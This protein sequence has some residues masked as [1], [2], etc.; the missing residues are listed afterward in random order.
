MHIEPGVVEGAKNYLSYATAAGAL[1]YTVKLSL[2]IIKHDGVAALLLRSAIATAL[3]FCF[4]EVLPH[5]PVGVSEVHLVLGTTLLLIFGVAPAA[6]GLSIGLLIQGL[7][8]E[9]QDIP[10]YGMNVTT[11]LVPL[12]ACAAL[13]RH[14]IPDQTAYVNVGYTQTLKLSMTFQGGIVAWVGFWA[15]YGKGVGAQ[16]L[17]EIGNFSV[18]YMSVVLVE[19]LIDL[20]LLSTA[21]LLQRLKGTVLVDKRLYNAV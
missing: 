4:F 5:Q 2:D 14:I 8:F 6:I 19:P 9:H 10:Q 11:L 17:S 21:K 12:L 13:A 15:L 3:V 7:F 1:G 16:N 20:G 18:A